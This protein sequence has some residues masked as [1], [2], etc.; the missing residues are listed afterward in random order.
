M[1]RLYETALQLLSVDPESAAAS[2]LGVFR[3]VFELSAIS[4]FDAES[5]KL[6][7]I[8]HSG[9]DLA[10]KTQAAFVKREDFDDPSSPIFVRCFRVD[11]R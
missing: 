3:K 6:R 5:S 8:G 10:G 2:F 1:A 9:N 11:G 4:L 7:L